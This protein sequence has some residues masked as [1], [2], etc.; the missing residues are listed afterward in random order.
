MIFLQFILLSYLVSL[1]GFGTMISGWFIGRCF[2]IFPTPTVKYARIAYV[3]TIAAWLLV[4]S[5]LVLLEFLMVAPAVSAFGIATLFVVAVIA[6][7]AG[8][9]FGHNEQLSQ[10]DL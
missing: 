5:I 10:E 4:T 3:W 6:P 1:F 8:A 9:C 2:R 7:I